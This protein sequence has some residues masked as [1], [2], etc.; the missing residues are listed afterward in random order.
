M[1]EKI[2]V[3]G[4]GIAGLSTAYLAQ[5]KYDITLFEKNNYIGGHANTRSVKIDNTQISVDT[6]FIVFNNHTYPNL[7]KL[8]RELD[9]ETFESDMS[10]SF[11]S[12]HHSFE[13]GGGSL[14]SLIGDKSNLIKLSFY[15]MIIDIFRFYKKFQKSTITVPKMT[16]EEYCLK[17][18]YSKAFINFHLLPLISSIWSTPNQLSMKQPLSNIVSFFQNH[19][20]FNF[21]DRPQ[22][23]TV[24]GGSKKYIEKI[25][26]NTKM[27][28]NLSS[29]IEK[30]DVRD[31]GFD[32]YRNGSSEHFDKIV[33]AAPPN[34]FLELISSWSLKQKEI[35]SKF[36]FQK[37]HVQLHQNQSTMPQYKKTWSSW[38]FYT[39][40]N[41][42]FSLTYWMNRLQDLKTQKNIFVSL[43]QN[44]KSNISYETHYDHPVM[45][46]EISSAQKNIGTIQ[47]VNNIYYVGSYLGFGFH[48]D[49]IQSAIKVCEKLNVKF[50][51][52]FIN[53]DTSRIPWK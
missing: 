53:N 43:N 23:K 1:R 2:A 50:S 39:N 51:Q 30:I 4:S 45:S 26:H 27:K 32:I 40:Q 38:N 14:L 21:L 10:F 48:E 3:I 35:L 12:P 18:N 28:I 11:Y 41:N 44:F 13:Y 42:N 20:L 29:Q 49:G 31:N 16:V 19:K 33:F 52:N 22:W 24:R 9:V 25:I 47:G 46:D 36:K 17:N 6:G 5:H 8:F 15:R 34:H 37:N 7:I